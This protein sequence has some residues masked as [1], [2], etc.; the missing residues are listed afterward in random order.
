[1]FAI[2]ENDLSYIN[3][4]SSEDI[5]SLIIV[6]IVIKLI[7]KGLFFIGFYH[8]IKVLNF[9]TLDG[10]FS[11]KKINL[12]KKSGRLILLSGVIGIFAISID[13]LIN[14]FNATFSTIE[15]NNDFLYSLYF[16]A[17]VGLFLIVFS[18][19]LER[20]SELKKENEL[21]I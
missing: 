11:I 13:M 9:E 16:S 2:M 5:T 10:S 17:I 14:V 6:T 15:Q 21:T 4:C 19:I 7:S 12:F 8:L 18:K 20:A 1:M 3:E